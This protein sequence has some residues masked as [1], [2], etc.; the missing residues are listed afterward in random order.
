MKRQKEIKRVIFVS[1]LSEIDFN[2]FGVH[3]TENLQ[4]THLGGG[5]NGLSEAKKYKITV[6]VKKYEVNENAT[7]ISRES[8]PHEKEVVLDFDQELNCQLSIIE[9]N[10]FV[11]ISKCKINTG[12]R[13]DLWVRN[14][15]KII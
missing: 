12:Q 10:E 3:F 1:D 11:S 13:S 7:N 8:F 4:Y 14:S 15:Y 2:N 9:N 5:S 6:F